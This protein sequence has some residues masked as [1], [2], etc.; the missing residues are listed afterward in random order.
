MIEV[1]ERIGICNVDGCNIHKENGD[2]LFCKHH[3]ISW[4][5][6]CKEKGIEFVPILNIDLN[7]ELE[8][9]K[10]TSLI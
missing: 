3:R 1:K 7:S 5:N 8:N 4:R 2:L 10:N 9:F 6:N